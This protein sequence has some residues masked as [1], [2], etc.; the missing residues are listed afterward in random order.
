MKKILILFAILAMPS[1]AYLLMRT[2]KNKYITLE[3]FGPKEPITKTVNGKVVVDTIYH[4]VGGFSLLNS[5]SVMVTEKL[6]E[7]KIFVADFFF[8]TCSSICPKMSG[9]LMRVQYE[10]KDDSSVVILSHTVDPEHDTPSVLKEYAKKYEAIPGK[11]YFLTGDKK[12]IYDLARNNYFIS[13]TEGD[14]G[15]GDFIHSEQMVLVDKKKHIRGYYDGTDVR[16]VRRLMDEIK[17]LEIEDDQS[18]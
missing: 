16:D 17:L 4:S 13:A 6:T 12:A 10:Y 18:K 15:K 2:G 8:T 5:D 1:I 3:T 11:W 7:G 9:Q 14:G